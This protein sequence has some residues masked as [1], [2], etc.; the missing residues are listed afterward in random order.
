MITGQAFSLYV[1]SPHTLLGPSRSVVSDRTT[2]VFTG[3][4]NY[5]VYKYTMYGVRENPEHWSAVTVFHTCLHARTI[6]QG[7]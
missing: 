1:I 6:F 7:K 4:Y 2:L 5:T 3:P